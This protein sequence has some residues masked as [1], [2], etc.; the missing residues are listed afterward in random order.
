MPGQ[1]RDVLEWP[2]REGLRIDEAMHPLAIFATGMYG[3]ELANQNGAPLR[4][5]VPWK[6]G[7]KSIKSIVKVQP[8][9]GAS[10]HDVG[11]VGARR[12]RLLRQRESGRRSP[13]LERSAS[14]RRLGDLGKRPTL[15]FNGYADRGGVALRG[16]GSAEE[17]LVTRRRALDVAV[18][19]ACTRA[20]RR[21]WRGAPRPATSAPIRSRRSST[22][23]AIWA[24]R[25]LLATL[26]VTPLRRLAGWQAIATPAPHA[27]PL[28]V[29]ATSRAHFLIWSVLDNGLDVPALDRG[30]RASA[31]S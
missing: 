25:L 29:R 6:Y 7:F 28:R 8:R 17:L 11:R 22:R 1:K 26:A 5:V 2:Y 27:R 30:H 18:I 14:E 15:P 21:G 10:L 12:V 4:L 13:A 3:G 24:L 31:P 9:R 19:A 23:P 16:H 20:R